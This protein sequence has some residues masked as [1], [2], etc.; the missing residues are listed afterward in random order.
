MRHSGHIKPRLVFEDKPSTGRYDEFSIE[1]IPGRDGPLDAWICSHPFQDRGVVFQC[2]RPSTLFFRVAS[3]W[4]ERSF[5]GKCFGRCSA[6][7][8]DRLDEP[9]LARTSEAEVCAEE[10]HRS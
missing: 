4:Y 10:V 8:L 1:G 5:G 6:H 3:A 2:G 9:W 7:D